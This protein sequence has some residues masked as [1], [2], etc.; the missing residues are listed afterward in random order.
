MNLIEPFEHQ[1]MVSKDAFSSL[2]LTFL[3]SS[4]TAAWYLYY[5]CKKVD[6]LEQK[7][8]KV[9]TDVYVVQEEQIVQTNTLEDYDQRI[10]QKQDYD[11]GD[12]L[13]EGKYQAWQG[14]FQKDDIRLKV[15][16]WREKCSTKNKNQEWISWNQ[17]EET[18]EKED[19]SVVVRDFYLGNSNP[20]FK[21]LLE[22]DSKD[23]Y[24]L[25]VKDTMINGWDS[26]IK[27]EITLSCTQKE[28]LAEFIGAKEY[29][30]DK[31][32][33]S[34]LQKCIQD[35]LIEWQKILIDT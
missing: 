1:G 7:L 20:E 16:I 31:T 15:Y 29:Q 12:D 33:N 6:S 21:W 17:M 27:I 14:L 19:P 2:T 23:L 28:H 10:R 22:S 4:C 25:V 3:V 9:D 26:L 24:R 18:D 30:Y 13:E 11:E 8:A 5:L 32:T 35:K 34:V